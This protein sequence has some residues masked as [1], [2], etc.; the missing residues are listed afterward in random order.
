MSITLKAHQKKIVSHM[1]KTDSRGII[2]FHG[3]GSGKT[4]TSIAISKL[5]DKKVLI[6]VPASMRTQWI[7]EL[8]KMEVNMKNYQVISYEGFL[9]L[10]ESGKIE[11]LEN[12]VILVDEAHRIRSASGKI[13]TTI[14]KL[15][16][17][18]DKV[19]LLTGTPMVNSPID[20][21]PLIN[22]IEGQNIL[23]T[24]E[25]PFKEKFYL[26]QSKSAPRLDMRC[27]LYSSVTCSN[28]GI[29]YKDNLCEYH[30]V[31]SARRSKKKI[32]SDDL[33]GLSM[34]EWKKKQ[35]IRINKARAIVNL[36][37]LKPNTSEYS[38]FVNQM[39]SYYRPEKNIQDFPDT[40]VKKI[41]VPMS[42]E[43][44]KI[45]KKAQRGVNKDDL[46][47]LKSGIEVTRKTSAMNAFLN[48]TRQISNTWDGNEDTPKLKKVLD[49]IVKN[50]KP[51]LVYSNWIGNG[52]RPLSS[53]LQKKNI[54]YLEFIGGMSDVK[55]KKVVSDYNQ[56]KIDVLLLSS[57]GGEGL[58][59]KNTRQIHIMEP[60]WN[61][62]KIS[63]VIGRGV[64]YKSHENL[65][66]A[67][68]H[69]SVFHW[70]STPLGTTDMGTDEYLYQISE[71]KIEEMKLFLETAIKNSVENSKHNKKKTQK[72]S[73][74]KKSLKKDLF[75]L[76]MPS[77]LSLR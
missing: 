51:A 47:L 50:P 25:E 17:T 7:P 33:N 30:Y 32:T 15:L 42:V 26:L 63:Q 73:N 54:N 41:K 29:K 14:V 38:K 28:R 3:L 59:L 60:H 75:K 6:I 71:K 58:N 48:A 20:M 77:Y 34:K 5:Y 46:N 44:D 37:I 40:T 39:V 43:Q 12:Q 4:I 22:A 35:D 70:I 23:P 66:L 55:K 31:K 13:S 68:R 21:S 53:M 65:P 45:Y 69:V 2:L 24:T 74:L 76:D 62:A 57:S 16:Q 52:I 18:A 49:Y 56:G 10:V 19:I 9:S 1:K 67:E 61:E 11:S 64:R 27:K 36:G 72:M 8:K